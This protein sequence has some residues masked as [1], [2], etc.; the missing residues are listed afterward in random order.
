MPDYFFH[1]PLA[2]IAI[3]NYIYNSCPG[4]FKRFVSL[5]LFSVYT[6]P[7]Q[8]YHPWPPMHLIKLQLFAFLLEKFYFSWSNAEISARITWSEGVITKQ[9]CSVLLNKIGFAY[10]VTQA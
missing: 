2:I 9:Y 3:R 7:L 10:T 4:E 5:Q 6:V 8:F 1:A